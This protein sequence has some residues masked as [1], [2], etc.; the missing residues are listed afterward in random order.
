MAFIIDEAFNQCGKD[1][2]KPYVCYM[3]VNKAFNAVW[4]DAMLYKRYYMVVTRKAKKIISSCMK[5]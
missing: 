5:I 3:D 4:I 1:V 2:D